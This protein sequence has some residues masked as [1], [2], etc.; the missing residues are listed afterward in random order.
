MAGALMAG[1]GPNAREGGAPGQVLGIVCGMAA[2]ARALGSWARHPRIALGLSA[3]RPDR[4]E[5]EAVR[6]AARGVRILL[7]WGIAGALDPQLRP[8]TLIVPAAVVGTQGDVHELAPEMLVLAGG[9]S[10]PGI[11][12]PSRPRRRGDGPASAPAHTRLLIAGSDVVVITP[13]AKAELRRRTGAAAVDMESHRLAAVSAR[14]GLPCLAVRAISDPADR[15]LPALSAGAL[16]PDGRPR[17]GAV[18][19]RLLR[20][21]GDLPALIAAARDSRAALTALRSAADALMRDLLA[22]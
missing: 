3:G 1:A 2:E 19:A 22:R 4:A 15:A 9:A 10:A 6:L 5:A 11:V 21:P 14:A 13:A 17:I 18:L 7:S 8:G 16:G 12:L 20:R